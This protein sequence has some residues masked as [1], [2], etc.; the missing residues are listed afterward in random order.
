VFVVALV[1]VVLS[2]LLLLVALLLPCLVQVPV[3]VGLLTQ[4]ETWLT[5]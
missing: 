1:V 2:R 4:S 3:P 5:Y